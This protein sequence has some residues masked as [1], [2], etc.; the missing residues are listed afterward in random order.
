MKPSFTARNGLRQAFRRLLSFEGLECRLAFSLWNPVDIDAVPSTIVPRTQMTNFDLF[1]LNTAELK[2]Q[3]ETAPHEFSGQY[4][5]ITVTIP[6]PDG[7]L[8]SFTVYYSPV[9]E[10]ALAAQF[11][12]IKTYAG[13]G[14]DNPQSTVRFDITPIG[15]HAQVLSEDGSYYVDPYAQANDELYLSYYPSQNIPQTVFEEFPPIDDPS[16]NENS[17]SG[18]SNP[19]GE[20]E[21]EGR[22]GTVLREYRLAVAT[23][24]EYSQYHASLNTG[25][26]AATASLAAVVVA[27]NRV[28]GVYRTELSV[29]MKLIANNASIIFTDANTDPYSNNNGGAMLSENQTTLD[30]IIGNANYDIGHVF[31]TG[32]GGVASLGSVGVNSRKAQGV[33]GLP[34]PI[35]DAFYIDYVAHEVGHQFGG[36]HTFNSTAGSCGG[37][38]RNGSTAY[39]PGSGTTIM[40]YAGICGADDIQPHSDPYFHSISFDEA[41]RHVD[42]VIP[43]V[44]RRTNTGNSVP[45]VNAGAD[46]SI[47]ARTPFVL[48][49]SG[50]DGDA[51][52]VLTYSWDERDLGPAQAL[53][54]ADNGSSPL[55]RFWSPTTDPSRYFPQLSSLINN[56]VPVGEQLPTTTRT[57]NF[58]ATVRD[59]RFTGGG[60]NTDDMRV[61]VVDTG[62]AFTVTAPNSAV[63][64]DGLSQQTVSWNVANTTAAPISTSFVDIYFSADGGLTY[65]YL[66]AQKVANNGQASIFVPNVG[67]SQGRIMVRGNNNIFFDISDVDMTVISVPVIVTVAPANSNYVENSPPILIAGQTIVTLVQNL[68]GMQVDI[69]ITTGGQFG[70]VIGVSTV[71]GVSISGTNID[72]GGTTIG[73]VVAKTGTSISVRFNGN[74]TMQ[75]LESFLR[76]MTFSNTTDNPRAVPRTVQFLFGGASPQTVNIAVQPTNDAPVLGSGSLVSIPE[77]VV[78]VSGQSIAQTLG[79]VFVDPDENSKFTGIVVVGNPSNGA[80][81][82]WYYSTGGNFVP[83]GA[84]SDVNGLVLDRATRIGFLPVADYFGTPDPLMVKALDDTYTGTFSSVATSTRVIY[85]AVS[86]LPTTISALASPLNIQVTNVN[87]APIATVQQLDVNAIQDQVLNFVVDPGLFI[88]ID[89]SI[90]IS[91]TSAGSAAP[92][93]LT[94]DPQTLTLSG[95]PRNRDVGSYTL[96]LTASDGELATSIP[97]VVNVANVNDPPEQLRMTGGSVDEGKFAVQIGSLFATD[98]DGDSIFWTSSDPRFSIRDGQIILN[99][100]L[101]FEDPSQRLIPVTFTANDTGSPTES[102]SMDVAIQVRDVNEAYPQLVSKVYSVLDGTSAGA[103]LDVL[104]AFDADTE[105][106]VRY[107]LR[108]GDTSFFNI[109]P[110]TGVF[111]LA[112]TADLTEQS[113]YKVFVEAY[114]DGTPSFGTT[115]QMVINVDPLNLF[116][117][118]FN[119]NQVLTFDENLPAGA[120]IGRVDVRDQDG[121]PLLFEILDVAGGSSTWFTIDPQNGDLFLTAQHRFDFESGLPYSVEVQV[122]ETIN[123]GNT[124]SGVIPI[125]L[126]NVNEAP[127]GVGDLR[128]YPQRF[129]TPVDSNFAIVDQDPPIQGY[130]ITTTDSRFEI[131]NGRLALKPTEIQPTSTVGQTLRVPIRVVDN[132]DLSS[133]NLVTNVKVV[134]ATPW[135]NPLNFLDTNRDGAVTNSDALLIIN[136]LND[137]LGARSLSVPRSFSELALGDIDSTGDNFLSAADALRVINSLNVSRPGGEG[138]ANSSSESTFAPADQSNEHSEAWLLA[139][140]QL[141]D[142][143]AARR[144]K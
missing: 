5:N 2:S 81:G 141:E 111:R 109:D 52:D 140:N 101:D 22:S 138:E 68:V 99:D 63:T 132:G 72:F 126:N 143:L 78:L 4:S 24:G 11:P 54:A 26:S 48:T 82:T 9:M 144:R 115:A 142:E 95:T 66:I 29:T 122:T 84:V 94:Y 12:D 135:Q 31:S 117:P 114:D 25:V 50:V 76:S 69:G 23:T 71:N 105:Q 20:G 41:I 15:F 59:N 127:T 13:Q 137:G 47:P 96:R 130:T 128:I 56:T 14:I 133:V 119:S 67:T 73:S 92:N 45:I 40:A 37:G 118:K 80:Q 64:W 102:T 110:N 28:D 74:S 46:Y 1:S 7:R 8:E 139:Y 19:Q 134:A 106:T 103:I 44:G 27:V 112:K 88:D 90:T 77:D 33:T 89:S 21:N 129:G 60:V 136:R 120:R 38:N 113:Q 36:N 16:I 87:D 62:A 116:V 17:N 42:T 97:L 108:S 104:N 51:A 75:S 53:S 39:E 65:P 3:V 58:R 125:S 30:N 121:N 10:D 131:R 70:D 123:N 18:D 107:R 6:R 83:I 124:V 49:A 35:D 100:A 43:S 93:W 91:I 55:F 32:G 79:P 98:P 57:M 34:T 85:N 61:S 86:W